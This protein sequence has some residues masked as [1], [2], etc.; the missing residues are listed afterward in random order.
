MAV[1]VVHRAVSD[2]DQEDSRIVVLPENVKQLDGDRAPMLRWRQ[3]E[4]K[5]H[6]DV[7]VVGAGQDHDDER[8]GGVQAQKRRNGSDKIAQ[9]PD[10]Y[11]TVRECSLGK[12]PG[13]AARLIRARWGGTGTDQA[14]VSSRTSARAFALRGSGRIVDLNGWFSDTV[15][16]RRR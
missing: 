2:H 6:H 5:G 3:V 15:T 10:A 4:A 13:S 9:V 12:E 11:N 7:V 14:V 16:E 8:I 1:Q